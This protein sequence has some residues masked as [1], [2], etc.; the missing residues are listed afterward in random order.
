MH[1]NYYILYLLLVC[2]FTACTPRSIREAQSVVAQ[3]DSLW[4]AGKQYGMDEGDSA[5]LAQ[6]YETLKKYSE[7]SRQFSEICPFIPCTSSLCTYAHACYHYG[8]LLREKDNPVEAMQ[9]FINATHSRTRDYHILGRVYSNMGDICQQAGEYSLAYDMFRC[10]SDMFIGDGDSLNYFYTLNEMAFEKAMLL[11]NIAVDSLTNHILSACSDYN[12]LAST[13]DTKAEFYLQCQQYDSAL[14]YASQ[15]CKIKKDNSL[16][17]LICAQVYSLCGQKDSAVYYANQVLL[18]SPNLFDKNNAL[19]IL[20]NDDE[21]KDIS[22]VRETAADRSDVQKQLEIRQGK[23]SQAVQLL[24]LDLNRKPSLTWL[25]AILATLFIVGLGT[26]LYVFYKGKKHNLLTQK[27]DILKQS[28]SVLQEKHDELSVRYLSNQQRAEED[29]NHKCMLLRNKEQLTTEL[30]WSDFNAMC[31]VV[32][33]ELYLLAS[34]L[35]QKQVLN[36]TEI[37]LCVLVLIGLSRVQISN[38]LPYAQNSIGKLKD[39]TAKLLGTTGKNLHE[40]LLNL[41][42]EG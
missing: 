8:R 36:E 30:A 29:I 10:A 2:I 22:S 26:S 42:I 6:A 1:R 20:T 3:A 32:D 35:Q 7:V 19:Y 11:D 5:T 17:I 13:L 34:K 4:H 25:Y 31:D 28:A 27:V 12:L 37:R 14:N 40:Y 33:T 15:S 39:H 41:A 16:G 24:E 21:D 18:N 23:L 9:V 38:T